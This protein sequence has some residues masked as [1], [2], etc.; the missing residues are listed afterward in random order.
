MTQEDKLEIKEIIKD[1]HSGVNA[2]IE[3]KYDVIDIKLDNLNAH[4]TRQNSKIFKHEKTINEALE[5]RARN[6]QEQKDY[7]KDFEENTKKIRTLEDQNLSNAS[8]KKF[9][10]I[11]FGGGI[12][13]GGLVVAIIMI[14][15]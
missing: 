11:M 2:R 14:F 3:A 10:G 9:L 8:V 13:L 12:A 1:V 7:F 6:R 5:E 4:L 15:I